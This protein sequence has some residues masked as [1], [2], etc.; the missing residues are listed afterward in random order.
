[1]YLF[2]DFYFFIFLLFDG[3][4]QVLWISVTFSEGVTF[5]GVG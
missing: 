4:L 5:R 1:M 2:Y 3:N